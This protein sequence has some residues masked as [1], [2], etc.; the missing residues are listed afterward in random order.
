[1]SAPQL[2]YITV[3]LPNQ[4]KLA[5]YNL[6]DLIAIILC[7]CLWCIQCV[8]RYASI[9][10]PNSIVFVMSVKLCYLHTHILALKTFKLALWMHSF[11]IDQKLIDL[12]WHLKHIQNLQQSPNTVYAD[13][14]TGMT[15]PTFCMSLM[16]ASNS[17]YLTRLCEVFAIWQAIIICCGYLRTPTDT[18]KKYP[19]YSELD[20]LCLSLWDSVR[21]V[22]VSSAN[23]SKQL[24]LYNPEA[25]RTWQPIP[26]SC[27]KYELFEVS[28]Y[29]VHTLRTYQCSLSTALCLMSGPWFELRYANTTEAGGWYTDPMGNS[30][31]R[32]DVFVSPTKIGKRNLD[33]STYKY[34]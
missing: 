18:H 30:C 22:V 28:F 24:S 9:L 13:W 10:F 20:L 23:K 15:L 33:K 25:H 7:F 12:N 14:K 11:E 27:I 6:K 21:T 32:A 4:N 8:G 31:V 16:I 17:H 1:M 19:H 5:R 34:N 26:L 3:W 29:A 2:V